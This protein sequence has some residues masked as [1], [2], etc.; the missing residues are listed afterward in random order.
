MARSR[1]THD[2]P[3]DIFDNTRMSFADHIGELQVRMI[4]AI[5]G[6][7]FFMLIGF[8]LDAVG[9]RV[10]NK[11]IGVG[12][13]MLE[14]ITDP[15]ETQVLDFYNRRNEKESAEKL[16][17]L[18]GASPD[19]IVAIREKLRR[20]DN[21]LSALSE[22]ERRKLMGAPEEMPVFVRPA[23]LAA[24]FGP[25]RADAPAEVEL[26]MRVYP[27]YINYLNVKGETLLGTKKYLSTLSA[28]EGFVV[29]FKVTALC[30][31]VLASP[32][33]LYQ[34]WAFVGVGLYPHERRYVAVM[35][36]PSVVLFVGGVLICQ[37]LVL[38]GA[39]KAL[40]RFNEFLGLDPDIRM[41]E[42]LGLALI[43]PLVFGVS[44]Q[45]PLVMIFFNRIGLF[46]AA[47]YLKKW[48]YACFILALV[49]ALITPT[50][51]VV[52]MS[53]LFVPMFGL[54]MLGIVFCHFFP[55]VPEDVEE[56]AADEIA[57]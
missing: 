45:T 46:T 7:V 6:L 48:R 4:R 36:W 38:P 8:V 30:G 19:E 53:Y 32:W 43:L 42:W 31:V 21:A 10:G 14:V 16:A 33:I 25:P 11:A 51:D 44:F 56:E 9:Q 40:L 41:N 35:F 2:Y 27:A 54:Y 50:P 37:F 23:D 26:R 1:R 34:F 5:L 49:A 28:Q 18:T 15:V 3:D 24:A 57:V 47:D 12:R 13:P 20:H 52:T 17:K 55:G 39:V 22:D 29:Y